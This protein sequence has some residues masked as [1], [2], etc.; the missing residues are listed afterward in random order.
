MNIEEVAINNIN[1]STLCDRA[2]DVEVNSDELNSNSTESKESKYE[3]LFGL[4]LDCSCV[5]LPI[6][7]IGYTYGQDL[8]S[9]IFVCLNDFKTEKSLIMITQALNS[10]NR[11]YNKTTSQCIAEVG[12]YLKMNNDY[13]SLFKDVADFYDYNVDVFLNSAVINLCQLVEQYD[14]ILMAQTVL[15]M[16]MCYFIRTL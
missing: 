5:E 6:D 12:R 4:H 13:T 11:L 1:E 15:D 7:L 2:A 10:L 3:L 8:I 14:E 9:V 16:M